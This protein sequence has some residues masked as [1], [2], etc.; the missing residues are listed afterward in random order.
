M[1]PNRL[2][3]SG[4]RLLERRGFLGDSATALGSIAL[5]SLLAGDRLLASTDPVRPVIDPAHPYASRPSHFPSKAKNVLVIFC[6]GAVSQLE[7]WDWK[8]EL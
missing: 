8:P 3:I 6:A 2:S 1:F 4:R 7:T 5:S